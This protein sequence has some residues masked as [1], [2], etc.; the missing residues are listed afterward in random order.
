MTGPN[1][2]IPIIAMTAGARQEDKARC[3]AVGMDGYLVKRIS[4]DALLAMLAR[5]VADS[6]EVDSGPVDPPAGHEALSA[7]S[8][9]DFEIIDRLERLGEAAG[10]DLIGQLAVLFVADAESHLLL[11]RQAMAATDASALRRSAHSIKGAS[12]NLGAIHLARLCGALEEEDVMGKPAGAI[13]LIGAIEI[14]L[15]RVRV[16]LGALASAGLRR[17]GTESSVQ[18]LW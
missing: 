1:R 5:W 2:R 9:L 14:E 15:E 11:L 16:A 8:V 4:R 6:A 7:S 10:E 17:V 12:A 13:A 18:K 3:L